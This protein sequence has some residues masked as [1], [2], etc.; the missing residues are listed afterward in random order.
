MIKNL[1]IAVAVGG[2]R[3]VATDYALSVAALSTPT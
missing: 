2:E 1:V 3:G